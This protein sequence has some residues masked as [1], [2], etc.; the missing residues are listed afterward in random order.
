MQRPVLA[1]QVRRSPNPMPV[2][3]LFFLC[4]FALTLKRVPCLQRRAAWILVAPLLLLA[5]EVMEGASL[6][7]LMCLHPDS[8]KALLW[9]ADGPAG[10]SCRGGAAALGEAE[11]GPRGDG[12]VARPGP[13]GLRHRS[14]AATPAGAMSQCVRARG[15]LSRRPFGLRRMPRLSGRLLPATLLLC[16]LGGALTPHVHAFATDPLA[17]APSSAAAVAHPPGLEVAGC[18]ICRMGAQRVGIA[19]SGAIAPYPVAALAHRL[20]QSASPRF[21]SRL[22][23]AAAPP[24]APPA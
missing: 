16:V 8:S 10:R 12:P 1:G 18:M 2:P 23:R 5:F 24:R 15:M 13:L 7:A 20:P 4:L 6:L 3:T 21:L 17:F 14:G 19:G 22:D 11:T 9:I